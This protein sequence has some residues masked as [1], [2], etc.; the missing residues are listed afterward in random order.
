MSGVSEALAEIDRL[1]HEP[2]RLALLTAL[3]AVESADFLFLQR[4]TGLTAGNLSTHLT[5][6]EEGGLV[7]VKK[8]IRGKRPNTEIGLTPAGREAIERHWKQLE[9]LRQQAGNLLKE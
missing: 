7:W 6:L 5:R 2:A 3:S 9:T 4:L 8:T 1:I